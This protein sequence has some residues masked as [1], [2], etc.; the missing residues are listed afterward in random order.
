MKPYIIANEKEWVKSLYTHHLLVNPSHKPGHIGCSLLEKY[1]DA[2]DCQILYHHSFWVPKILSEYKED[3]YKWHVDGTE[4]PM[5]ISAY[6]F[7]TE[8][9]GLETAPGDL[10][11]MPPKTLHRTNPLSLNES[12]LVL[13][14]IVK[15][16]HE[17]I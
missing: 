15:D 6:P 9:K 13:R 14:V 1:V 10:I 8:V 12:R 16:N 2:I 4:N 11:F 5:I 17:Q 3:T 7:N